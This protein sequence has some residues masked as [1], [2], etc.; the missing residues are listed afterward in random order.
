[1]NELF[2][3]KVA[4]PVSFDVLPTGK[5]YYD[6]KRQSWN[7]GDETLRADCTESLGVTDVTSCTTSRWTAQYYTYDGDRSND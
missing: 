6:P 5:G 4:V 2:A 1:M 3:F 7:S